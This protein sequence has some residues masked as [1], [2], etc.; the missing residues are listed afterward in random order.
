VRVEGKSVR[1]RLRSPGAA[2]R[3]RMA[4]LRPGL[5]A[6]LARGGLELEQLEVSR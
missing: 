3:D 2:L 4:R 1:C 5:V 6:G